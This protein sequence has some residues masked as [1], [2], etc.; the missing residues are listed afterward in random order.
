MRVSDLRDE[1]GRR[2]ACRRWHESWSATRMGNGWR[3]ARGGVS[4]SS[5]PTS[6]TLAANVSARSSPRSQ[7]SS[8]RCDP[9]PDAL[10]TTRSTSLEG[11]DEAMRECL[12]LFEPARVHGECAA[13]ALRWRDDLEPVRGENTCRRGVHVGEDRALHA[14]GEE[15]DPR[16]PR[17]NRRGQRRDLAAPTPARGDL[18]ERPESPRQRRGAAERRQPERGAHAARIREHAEEEPAHEPVTRRSLDLLLDRRPCALDEAVVA[19]ARRARGDAC[20]AA[21]AAVEVLRDRRVQR[22]GAV[23]ARVHQVDPPARGVH[24]LAPEHVRRAGRQAEAAVDAVG[25]VLADHA[26]RIPCGSSSRR[27]RPTSAAAPPA[28]PGI[29]CGT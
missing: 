27:I 14:P 28:P 20:H 22:D 6:R 17:A 12:P 26:A 1:S 25:G 8:F 16:V 15:A 9:Q 29:S 10:T 13:A 5:S 7:P 23:E 11:V 4:A 24:L 18:D 3:A 19:H 2:W 21:E